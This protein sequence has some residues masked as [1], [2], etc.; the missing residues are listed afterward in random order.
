MGVRGDI[1]SECVRVEHKHGR[2]YVGSVSVSMCEWGQGRASTSVSLTCRRRHRAG[3][4]LQDPRGVL[5]KH[6]VSQ[7]L[8]DPSEGQGQLPGARNKD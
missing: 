1:E 5:R 8:G 6:R 4:V 3:L 2:A 7:A